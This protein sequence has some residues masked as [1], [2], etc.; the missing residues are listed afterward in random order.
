MPPHIQRLDH[1]A[2]NLKVSDRLRAQMAEYER[3]LGIGSASDWPDY[4]TRT[5]TIRGLRE[6]I[7]I[8]DQIE[9]ELRRA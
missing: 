5:G 7:E 6:A 2:L 9:D 1:P 8:C 3:Q 4:C